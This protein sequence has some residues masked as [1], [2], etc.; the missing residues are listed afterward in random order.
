MMADAD[1]ALREFEEQAHE[2]AARLL[3]DRLDAGMDP[4]EARESVRRWGRRLAA[5]VTRGV[6]Y[7]TRE[8]S[9]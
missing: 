8:V 4:T 1:T 2:V 9:R 7:G 6:E 5:K 3:S